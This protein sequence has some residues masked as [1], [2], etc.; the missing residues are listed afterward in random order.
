MAKQIYQTRKG[1]RV[2][3][4]AREV[5]SYVMK[6]RGWTSEQYSKEYDKLRNRLRAYE[7][8]QRQSGVSI[9]AQSPAHLLYF[10]S[11]ARKREGKEYRRTIEL[12]RI[13]SFPSISSGKALTKRLEKDTANFQEIYF[14]G[15]VEKFA[16]FINKNPKAAEIFAKIDDP[17]KLEQA[18]TDYANKLYAQIK[19]YKED[20]DTAAI[21]FGAAI[22]S[23]SSIEFSIEYL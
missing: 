7:A 12:E 5:K 9:E 16:G 19:Q 17:V 2:A 23:D 13:Y 14:I 21:P 11:K 20:Q 3:L 4:S 1:V 18:L 6:V 10:E 8:F 15:T 22:G